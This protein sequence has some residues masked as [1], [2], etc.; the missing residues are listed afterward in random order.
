VDG[1]ARVWD[2]ATGKPVLS[3][4]RHTD[5]VLRVHYSA[6]GRSIITASGDGIAR[7]FDAGTG[8]LTGLYDNAL[9]DAL[10]GNSPGANAAYDVAISPSGSRVATIQGRSRVRLWTAAGFLLHTF[11]GAVD[12]VRFINEA[13][14]E[15]TSADGLIR[16]WDTETGHVLTTLSPPIDRLILND[17]SGRIISV[18]ATGQATLWDSR[19]GMLVANMGSAVRAVALSRDGAV[20]LV[21]S[22][23]GISR[24]WRLSDGQLTA[25]LA[26]F[27]ASLAGAVLCTD[28][29]TVAVASAE[30][31]R[32]WS[33]LTGRSRQLT[34]V[35]TAEVALPDNGARAAT[36]DTAGV[37]TIWDTATGRS[38][39]TLD[40]RTNVAGVRFRVA[41]VAF[42]PAG[43]RVA[44][45][46]TDG[47]LRLWSGLTGLFLS[48][49]TVGR[50]V[51]SP[52]FSP[53][54]QTI[55]TSGDGSAHLWRVGSAA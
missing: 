9:L 49:Q 26:G 53:D 10:E 45:T 6:D 23:D 22:A 39:A 16:L 17:H 52:T 20:A 29:S 21:T 31:V 12:T 41:S 8:T 44:T 48:E 43:D 15:T 50:A 32:I 35:P 40:L 38:L 47:T 13:T 37:A 27:P 11:D 55:V 14:I 28:G 42:S 7:S 24:A 3:L 18:S 19:G 51:Q 5:A 46:N 2:A 33:T 4:G 36:V 30:G 34:T 25:A 1:V 54:G